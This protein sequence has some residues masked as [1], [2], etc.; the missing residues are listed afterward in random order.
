MCLGFS[1]LCVLSYTGLSS[2]ERRGEYDTVFS[3]SSTPLAIGM[4]SKSWACFSKSSFCPEIPGLEKPE[5]LVLA[6]A[7]TSLK[8]F[9]RRE[10][11]VGGKPSDAEKTRKF[12]HLG[13]SLWA[14]PLGGKVLKTLNLAKCRGRH[15]G[16][17]LS[18]THP[19]ISGRLG[20]TEGWGCL[21]LG[22]ERG[23]N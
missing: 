22:D 5:A 13:C 20:W 15:K 9:R 21:V 4:L 19:A 18:F 11:D 17:D 2:S 12:L 6:M 23:Q 1:F 16:K 3:S 14:R 7:A 10:I 8:G